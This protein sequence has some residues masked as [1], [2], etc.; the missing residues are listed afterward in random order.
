MLKFMRLHT[1][2]IFVTILLLI[3][4]AFCFFGLD[5]VMRSSGGQTVAGKMYGKPFDYDRFLLA[6][7]ETQTQMIFQMV[8]V[9]GIQNFEQLSALRNRINNFFTRQNLNQLTW[10]RLLLLKIAN[11]NKIPVDDSEVANWVSRFPLFQTD[12]QFDSNRYQSVL[13]NGFGT[14]SVTF[15]KEVRKTLQIQRL[16]QLT[17]NSI[18]VTEAELKEAFANENE[19]AQTEFVLITGENLAKKLTFKDEE[20]RDF[21]ENR[22]ELFRKPSEF[23]VAYFVLRQVELVNDVTVSDGEIEAYYTSNQDQFKQDE[24]EESKPLEEVRGEIEQILK[25]QKSDD[26]FYELTTDITIALIREESATVE[27]EFGLS[28]EETPFFSI[29]ES[30]LPREVTN[31]LFDLTLNEFSRPIQT[32]EGL[33]LVQLLEKKQSQLPSYEETQKEV[34]KEFGKV[35]LLELAKEEAEQKRIEIAQKIELE[36]LSFADA[37]KKAKLPLQSAPEFTRSQEIALIPARMQELAF[38]LKLNEVSEVIPT[39]VGALFF[40]TKE[41]TTPEYKEDPQL[42]AR[43]KSAKQNEVYQSWIN[44]QKQ[45]ANLIDFTPFF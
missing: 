6:Q 5:M 10:E 44:I 41:I 34:E 33:Y 25:D 15:E 43:L 13:R 23:K 39:E 21:Y 40:A 20:L 42:N 11:K 27:N 12:G 1:K 35:R 4:P 45:E 7:K 17:T 3:I 16:Q 18:S 2:R 14:S 22:M 29:Q 24:S 37:V 8:L 38:E 31:Q 30:P 26:L 9:F 32:Q 19:L 28:L 36:E